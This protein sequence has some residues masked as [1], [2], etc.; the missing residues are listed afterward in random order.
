MN[1]AGQRYILGFS[2][3]L[4]DRSVCIFRDAVPLIAIEEERL[5]RVK[6][7]LALYGE[8]RKNPSIFSQM[9]LEKS[10]SEENEARLQ[11]SIDYCLNALG[12]TMDDIDVIAGN[13]LHLAFPFHG[14]SIHINHHLAHASAAFYASG[15]REAAIFVADGY[16]DLCNS[17]C[18]ETLMLAKGRDQSIKKL[19]LVT[20]HVTSYYD[21]ENSLGVFYR[22]GTLLSGFGMFDEGKMMGLAA[23]GE[24]KYYDFIKDFLIFQ[25]DCVSIKNGE[26]FNAFSDAVQD[27][28]AFEL[29][30]NIAASFQRVF[31]E[32]V[33]FYIHHL[34]EI[35]ESENLCISGGI[36]LNC[37]MNAKALMQSKFKNVFVFPGPGDNGISFGAAYFVAHQ[38]LGLPRTEPLD[39]AYF[40]K[41]YTQSQELEVLEKYSDQVEFEELNEDELTTLAADLLVKDNVIMWFQEGCEFGPRALGHRSCLGNPMRVET[42]DYINAKVKFRETFRP[43]APIVLEEYMRDFFDISCPSP[44][45][46]F[47]PRVREKTK[48]MAPGIVHVDGTSRL[49][50]INRKQNAKLYSLIHKFFDQTQVPIILNTS[51]NGKDEPIVETP[52]DALKS[53][54]SSPVEHLFIDNYHITKNIS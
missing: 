39:I 25:P 9:E 28:S 12:I 45:M 35:A 17:Q 48:E 41:A 4:H 33:F 3:S 29:R 5:S 44:F 38:L 53:F 31:E 34:Y 52:E 13:S 24:P 22:I 37:V 40:G 26:L 14:N 27:R 23:Y 2:D 36:G 30:A 43:L 54:L 47:S 16:G 18:Y 8:S 11:P 46:L 49:Q 21:M 51:F 19:K 6:H 7:G 20:G 50:T 10:S 1:K 15:F 42:K 32:I